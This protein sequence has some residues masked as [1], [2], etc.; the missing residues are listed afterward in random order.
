MTILPT[1]NMKSVTCNT[2]RQDVCYAALGP[3]Y[4]LHHH[5]SLRRSRRRDTRN[6]IEMKSQRIWARLA[7]RLDWK[8]T[9]N[10]RCRNCSEIKTE[11][12][13]RLVDLQKRFQGALL[14]NVFSRNHLVHDH[15]A[16]HVP[17][18]KVERLSGRSAKVLP[19]HGAH[20]IRVPVNEPQELVQQPKEAPHAREHGPCERVVVV[21]QFGFNPFEYCAHEVAHGDDQR[22]VGDR[23]QVV[24]VKR[25][26]RLR[27]TIGQVSFPYARRC[28]HDTIT[29]PFSTSIGST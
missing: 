28:V 6:R 2:I 10:L 3:K 11:T 20:D 21:F 8:R 15:N 19:V 1:N 27:L 25:R 17:Q 24:S 5:H 9:A 14:L 26:G 18:Q 29:Y 4:R 7:G 12:G 13:T 16:Q 23:S 22:S